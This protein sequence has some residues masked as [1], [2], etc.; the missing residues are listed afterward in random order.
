MELPASLSQRERNRAD[1][2]QRK[3][4]ERTPKE[5]LVERLAC[6]FIFVRP[7]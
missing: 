2:K 7:S 3:Q 6:F 1:G 4:D 5:V